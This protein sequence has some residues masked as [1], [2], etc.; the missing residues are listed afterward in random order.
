MERR[1]AHRN[2]TSEIAISRAFY[3]HYTSEFALGKLGSET[4]V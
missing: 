4:G 3:R 2:L 1:I